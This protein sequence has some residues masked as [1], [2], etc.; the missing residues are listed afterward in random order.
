MLAGIRRLAE[1]DARA[2]Y[3]VGRPQLLPT[4]TGRMMRWRKRLFAFMARNAGS[5]ADFFGLPPNRV[6]ELGAHIE[7]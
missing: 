4:G 6:V 7:F 3:Y 5:A 2:A 1:A